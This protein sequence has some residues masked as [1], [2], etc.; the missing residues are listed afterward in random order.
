M[1][2]DRRVIGSEDS[3]DEDVN[4]LTDKQDMTTNGDTLFEE[5]GVTAD[6]KDQRDVAITA[7]RVTDARKVIV[8]SQNAV[9][10]LSMISVNCM[11]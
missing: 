5:E 1:E 3:S 11:N 9:V 7:K 2:E 8:I 10:V 4:N 6:N